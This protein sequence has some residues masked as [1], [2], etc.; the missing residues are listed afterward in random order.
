MPKAKSKTT[1]TARK[2]REAM[3]WVAAVRV[4]LGTLAIP[5]APF[6]YKKHFL[7]L[8]LMRPTK[9]VMLAAGFRARSGDVNLPEILIAA[10]PLTILG[11]WHSYYLGRAYAKEIKSDKLPWIASKILPSKKIKALQKVL[12]KKGPRLIFLGRLAAFPSALVAAAA[13]SSEVTSRDFLVPDGTGG[14]LSL[15]VVMAIGYFLGD[16]YKKGGTWVTVA[17]VAVLAVVAVLFGRYLKR[18]S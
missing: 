8:V 15:G 1:R 4:V 7:I 10:I 13:G 9:E 2:F 11:V 18:E 3:L 16:A 12:K 14:I 17:G 5:L 6:L